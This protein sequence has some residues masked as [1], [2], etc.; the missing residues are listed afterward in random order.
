MR[1]GIDIDGCINNQHDFVINYGCKYISDNKLTYTI[2][3]YSAENSEQIFGWTSEV[4]HDFW[5][6]YRPVLVKENIRPFCSEIINKLFD[7]GNEIYIITSRYNGDIWWDSDSR[8]N[9]HD[10]TMD[11]FK[12]Y[13]IKYTDIIF[14]QNK[15]DTIKQYNIDIMLED[16]LKN[17]E[18]ISDLIPVF[19]MSN[20]YNIKIN[21]DNV[22]RCYCWYD[23]Y[24]KFHNFIK[25]NKN[26]LIFSNRN[27][28]R[29]ITGCCFVGL[30]A[31][32]SDSLEDLSLFDGV[33]LVGGGDVDP[34]LY[35]QR[36]ISSNNIEKE[37][38]IKCIKCLDYFVKNNKPI[39]GICKGLQIINVYFGGNLKQDIKN[40]NF[41]TAMHAH[42]VVCKNK[43]SLIRYYGESFM[44][45]SLHHQCIDKLGS[46]LNISA[47][48]EDNVIEAIEKENLIAV[49]WH[50]ERLLNNDFDTIEGKEIFQIFKDFF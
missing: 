25:K 43:S 21:N 10:I 18:L 2:K 47:I 17:I 3:D 16:N 33:I 6:T 45:N 11:F 35:G 30:K 22:I 37:F 13:N 27:C 44:V 5:E 50:P 19:V 24:N 34:E 4:A 46:D 1:I 8:D 7:E 23:F 26:I 32:V 42:K 9:V 31:T 20:T 49:Q 36:N 12:H 14:S 41:P 28:D 38:D 40:H 15:L 29:Y 48:S 39:L